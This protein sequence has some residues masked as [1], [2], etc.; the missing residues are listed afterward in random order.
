VAWRLDALPVDERIGDARALRA[1]GQ[2]VPIND[3]WILATALAHAS[4]SSRKPQTST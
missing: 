1:A 3:S 4:Q 2:E